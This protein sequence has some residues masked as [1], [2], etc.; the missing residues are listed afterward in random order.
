MAQQRIR[1]SDMGDTSLIRATLLIAL[2]A[3]MGFIAE[4]PR[5]KITGGAVRALQSRP[6]LCACQGLGAGGGHAATFY[7]KLM[8]LFP[9]TWQHHH[10]MIASTHCIYYPM[11][12]PIDPW[13][14]PVWDSKPKT[15][16]F[17]APMHSS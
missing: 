11:V 12:N 8:K 14:G 13:P 9:P 17:F 2:L 15:R 1:G 4:W 16:C 5:K 6:V 3:A 7:Q 10:L